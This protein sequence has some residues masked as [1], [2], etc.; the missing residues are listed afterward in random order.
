MKS[1]SIIA[2]KYA[3]ACIEVFEKEFSENFSAELDALFTFFSSHAPLISLFKMR[4]NLHGQKELLKKVFYIYSRHNFWNTLLDVLERSA[5]LYMIF[6]IVKSMRM[7][8][9]EKNKIIDGVIEVYP[10]VQPDEIELL[11]SFFKQKVGYS[12]DA[13]VFV[14]PALIAGV[15]IRSDRFLWEQSIRKRLNAIKHLY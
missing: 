1:E 9:R 4:H 5:R 12:I 11:K 6:S 7:V 3:K 13:S 14:E 15:R 8:Y 10:Y 2:T